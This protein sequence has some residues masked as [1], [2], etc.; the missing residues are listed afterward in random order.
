M[1]IFIR[2][3]SHFLFSIKTKK[4]YRKGFGYW[5][6]RKIPLLLNIVFLMRNIPR[7]CRRK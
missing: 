1:F 6:D 3:I 5:R 4:R 2:I 7:G